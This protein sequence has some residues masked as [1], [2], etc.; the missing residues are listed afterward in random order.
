MG[1]GRCEVG[2]GALEVIEGPCSGLSVDRSDVVEGPLAGP[3]TASAG[4]CEGVSKAI[5][6]GRIGD[7]I[8]SISWLSS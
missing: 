1:Q 3:W 8:R 4:P 2:P 5:R 7:L 6:L